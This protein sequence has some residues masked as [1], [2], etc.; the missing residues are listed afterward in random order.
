MKDTPLVTWLD[1]SAS[2]RRTRMREAKFTFSAS[3]SS[4]AAEPKK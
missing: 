4:Q 2:F 1:R 3:A